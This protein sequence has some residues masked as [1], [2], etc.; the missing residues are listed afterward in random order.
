MKRI[1]FFMLL[2]AWAGMCCYGLRAMPHA[3]ALSLD[4]AWARMTAGTLIPL[5][6]DFRPGA[7]GLAEI[8]IVGGGFI[9]LAAYFWAFHPDNPD[10]NP[11][12][13][14]NGAVS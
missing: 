7:F 13:Q 2:A 6:A 11:Y 14:E 8:S 10:A 5:F 1:A 12:V 3:L 9:V 4:A